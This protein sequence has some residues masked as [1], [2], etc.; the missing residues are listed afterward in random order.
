MYK[1]RQKLTQIRQ[2]VTQIRQSAFMPFRVKSKLNPR[3]AAFAMPSS[4]TVEFEIRPWQRAA[5]QLPLSGSGNT[6]TAQRQRPLVIAGLTRN[7]IR[8]LRIKSA[9]TPCCLRISSGGGALGVERHKLGNLRQSEWGR[10]TAVNPV[11]DSVSGCVI[12]HNVSLCI[13]I[14]YMQ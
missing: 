12:I 13:K 11:R 8:R 10:K 5:I 7:L 14:P 9:M 6:I 3:S 4:D 1:N 2:I